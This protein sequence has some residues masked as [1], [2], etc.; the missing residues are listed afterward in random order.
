MSMR[1]KS[2]EAFVLALI[3]T[4]FVVPTLAADGDLTLQLGSW[5]CATPDNYDQIVSAQ[6]DG[7]S[8][9]FQLKKENEKTCVYM[10]DENLEEMMAPFV[11]VL[12][13]QGDKSKVTFFVQFEKRYSPTRQE[14]SQ[15][16]YTGWTAAS[17]VIPLVY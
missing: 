7:G 8:S 6:R 1:A 13:Q 16:K 17:N 10:D 3:G 14:M 4:L 12:E 9:P 2:A 5:V 11:K 15:V